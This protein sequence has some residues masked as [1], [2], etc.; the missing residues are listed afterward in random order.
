LINSEVQYSILL[1]D[2]IAK[3]GMEDIFIPTILNETLNER[4]N[5]NGVRV[6]N[7]ACP[8]V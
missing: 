6:V 3:V 2:F 4:S 1:G 5:N 8:K 7:F